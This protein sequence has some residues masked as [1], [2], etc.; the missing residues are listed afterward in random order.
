M[1]DKN[2]TVEP[3]Q[4]MPPAIEVDALSVSYAGKHGTVD[5]LAG[6]TTRIEG[7]EFLALVGRSGSGKST[8]L[9]AVGGLTA[10]TRGA[11]RIGDQQ[12]SEPPPQIRFVAQDYSQ[13]LLPWLTVRQNV[14]FGERHAVTSSGKF[15]VSIDEIIEEVGLSHARDRYPRELSGGMQQRVAIARA[16]ASRPEIILLDEAFGSV[17]AL[18]RATLQDLMLELWQK[19]GFTAVLVTHDIDEAIYMADRV[20]VLNAAGQ[21]LAAEIPITLPRPRRQIE[22]REHPRYLEYRRKLLESVL[23]KPSLRSAEAA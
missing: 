21:G 10:A 7:G 23:A 15:A 14:A 9:R 1:A 13:S 6:I 5:A 12:V 3:I 16:I 11:V 22:T 8:L 2:R 17:D 19:F 20:L 4:V 18:S